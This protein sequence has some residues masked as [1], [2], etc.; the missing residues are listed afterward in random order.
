M[1]I[2]SSKNAVTSAHPLTNIWYS[3]GKAVIF[4]RDSRHTA[5]IENNTLTNHLPNHDIRDLLNVTFKVRLP[6]FHN[7]IHVLG[8]PALQ[9]YSQHSHIYMVINPDQHLSIRNVSVGI[10]NV[11]AL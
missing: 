3:T 7:A 6:L 2:N 9:K 4:H 1:F 5:L 10:K 11:T 8:W